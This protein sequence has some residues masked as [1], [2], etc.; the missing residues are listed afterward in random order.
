[1]RKTDQSSPLALLFRDSEI[2]LISGSE[3]PSIPQ[4]DLFPHNVEEKDCFRFDSGG[5]H[6]CVLSADADV[7]LPEGV[8]WHGLRESW[9]LLPP[10]AYAAACKGA[11]LNHFAQ[12]VRFCG[13]CGTI[14]EK[15]SECSRICPQCGREFFPQLYPAIVVLVIRGEEALLVH[16]KSFRR[17]FYALVAGFVETGENLEQCVAR[18]IFEET[19][20]RV[21][22]IR[23]F[24]S[25]S[26]PFPSQ[27]MLGFTARYESGELRWADGELSDG[28]FF[29][30][31]SLPPL[32]TSPSLSRS[33]IDA[34]IN[35]EIK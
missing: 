34:W 21:S 16:A 11:E 35:G 30:R 29:T 5:R 8:G 3:G 1:M 26:W 7:S 22:D 14:L 31:H 15:H 20:L 4:L 33:I 25:Q 12:S 10:Q 6:Y 27:L 13:T 24:G 32:P 19:S 17:N 9:G 2:A 28:Q 23:Y 18:E